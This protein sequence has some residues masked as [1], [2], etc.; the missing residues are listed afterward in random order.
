MGGEEKIKLITQGLLMSALGEGQEKGCFSQLPQGP[1]VGCWPFLGRFFLI[2][3][4]S[5]P[6]LFQDFTCLQE[7]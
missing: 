6:S 4:L 5:T 2:Y 3:L 1:G 7:S